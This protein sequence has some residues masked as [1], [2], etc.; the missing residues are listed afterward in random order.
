MEPILVFL[1]F[2]Q[3]RIE[4]FQKIG[5]YT[6]NKSFLFFVL[7]HL[8][9]LILFSYLSPF[10]LKSLNIVF[11][12]KYH[13]FVI[14][15]LSAYF[16]FVFIFLWIIRVKFSKMI[17]IPQ[18]EKELWDLIFCRSNNTRVSYCSKPRYF[19]NKT[20]EREIIRSYYKLF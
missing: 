11:Q 6:F 3:P 16:P 14:N 15:K 17:L 20:M 9:S 19:Y 5:N 1:L 7:L 4:N 10:L 12:D 13:F 8:I 18:Q 2:P